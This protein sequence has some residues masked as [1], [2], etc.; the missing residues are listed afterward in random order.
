MPYQQEEKIKVPRFEEAAG[1]YTTEKVSQLM[2]KI[3]TANTK[4]EVAFRKA[5]WHVGLRY[6]YNYKKAPGRPDIAFVRWKI[7]IFIDGDFWHGY[8][9]ENKKAAIKSNQAYWLPKIERN[10][11]RDREVNELLA[12]ANWKVL[13]IWEHEVKKDFGAAFYRVL[14]FIEANTDDWVGIVVE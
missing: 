13:R 1:F 14:R 3:R 8:D 7:A 2:R 6:R 9:W 12:Q 11:Q 4:A 10:I 5:L